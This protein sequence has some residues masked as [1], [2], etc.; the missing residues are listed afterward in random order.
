MPPG[1][2]VALTAQ[3]LGDGELRLRWSAPASTGGGPV[4]GYLVDRTDADGTTVR[5]ATLGSSLREHT[6]V[7]LPRNATYTYSVRAVSL[8]GEG[9]AATVS[10]TTWGLASAPRDVSVRSFA[11]VPVVEVSW[12]APESGA[13]F[14]TYCL[15]RIG[16]SGGATL[17]AELDAS[18]TRYTDRSVRASTT[19]TYEV[20][21]WNPAGEG[22]TSERACGAWFIQTPATRC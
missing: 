7:G 13:P 21:A 8:V 11:V 15:D 3:P 4:T 19:S 9:V 17:V 20:R 6:D 1:A 22:A 10:G 14:L 12:S 2:P 16:A 18:V 5:V